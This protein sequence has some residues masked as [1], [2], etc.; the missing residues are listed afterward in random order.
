M[1]LDPGHAPRQVVLVAVLLELVAQVLHV[2]PPVVL[3]V[4]LLGEAHHRRRVRLVSRGNDPCDG[5]KARHL[6]AVLLK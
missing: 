6:L 3:L 4:L 1:V 5:R 2:P